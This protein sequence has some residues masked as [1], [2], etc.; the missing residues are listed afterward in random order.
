VFELGKIGLVGN[1]LKHGPATSAGM[2]TQSCP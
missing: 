1:R 2:L